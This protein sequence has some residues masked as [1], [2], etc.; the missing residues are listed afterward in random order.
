MSTV[1][2]KLQA[3]EPAIATVLSSVNPG[4][5]MLYLVSV[6]IEDGQMFDSIMC[7]GPRLEG[8]TVKIQL[9]NRE[10]PEIGARIISGM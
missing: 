1:M 5:N 10:R 2:E 6:I 9:I 8:T 3:G 7:F 4:G